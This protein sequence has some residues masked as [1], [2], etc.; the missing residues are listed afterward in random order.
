MKERYDFG[1]VVVFGD[2][3]NDLPMF[4]AADESYAVA[5]ALEELKGI[6]TGVIGRNDEDAVAHFLETRGAEIRKN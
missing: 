6:A 5:N 3:V 1:K 2:S 4:R